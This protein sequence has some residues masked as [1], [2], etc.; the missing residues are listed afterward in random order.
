MRETGRRVFR[1]FHL[2]E[3]RLLKDVFEESRLRRNIGRALMPAVLLHV[4][5]VVSL[6]RRAFLTICTGGVLGDHIIQLHPLHQTRIA[7]FQLV[8][9]L[10]RL[11]EDVKLLNG[12]QRWYELRLEVLD[13]HTLTLTAH[14]ELERVI[15]DDRVV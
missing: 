1:V 3:L 4:E 9:W 6:R 13:L 11:V 14:V 10:G 5:Q 7:V 8:F 12:W 15:I 2:R